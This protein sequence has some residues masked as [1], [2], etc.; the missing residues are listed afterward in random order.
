[1]CAEE[2]P[3][4]FL[5]EKTIVEEALNKTCRTLCTLILYLFDLVVQMS[6]KYF[7]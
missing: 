1:M 7:T 4:Y 5:W 6:L 3:P 2:K